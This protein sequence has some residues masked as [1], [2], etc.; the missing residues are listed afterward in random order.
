MCTTFFCQHHAPKLRA[1][2]IGSMNRRTTEQ[3]WPPITQSGDT[4]RDYMYRTE[5][6]LN[7]HVLL[8]SSTMM[9][10]VQTGLCDTW[11][12]GHQHNEMNGEWEVSVDACL[13]CFCCEHL[14]ACLGEERDAF[15]APWHTE[16][17]LTHIVYTLYFYNGEHTTTTW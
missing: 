14:S 3:V 2:T 15:E 4:Q 7:M 8:T 6:L 1:A 9:S 11:T 16:I 13:Y 17:H 12:H 5:P 10:N